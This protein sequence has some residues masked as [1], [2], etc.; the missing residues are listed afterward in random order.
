MHNHSILIFFTVS[1][2]YSCSSYSNDCMMNNNID[3]EKE[4]EIF[5]RV[6]NSQVI[7]LGEEYLDNKIIEQIESNSKTELINQLA[8]DKKR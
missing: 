2:A 6:D 5:K 3:K 1:S 8:K 7:E 4:D